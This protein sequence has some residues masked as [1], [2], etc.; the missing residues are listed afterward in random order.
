MTS[1]HTS[2]LPFTAL[3]VL[4]GAAGTATTAQAQVT[5]IDSFAAM[6]GGG[7][8]ADG[9]FDNNDFVVFIDRFFSSDT[10]ADLGSQGGVPG[11]D[12][13]YDNNDFVVFIDL[14]FSG[15]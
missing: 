12:G 14:F 8:G 4:L 2:F 1:A 15:C 11:S 3:C 10:S 13:L 6:P 7:P 9:L 5:V